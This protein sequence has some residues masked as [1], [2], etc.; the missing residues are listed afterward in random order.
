MPL[1]PSSELQVVI[2]AVR[3][4]GADLTPAIASGIEA[5]RAEVDRLGA[6]FDDLQAYG[7][8][9]ESEADLVRQVARSLRGEMPFEAAPV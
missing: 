7:I 1:A 6:L 3:P 5:L 2:S 8:W 9:Y 4:E